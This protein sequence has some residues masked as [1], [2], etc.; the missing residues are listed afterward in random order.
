ML[1][2]L[3]NLHDEAWPDFYQIW[4]HLAGVVKFGSELAQEL[5]LNQEERLTV[6]ILGLLHDH[7]ED[8]HVTL[9]V[10]VDHLRNQ[11]VKN[12]GIDDERML[13]MLKRLDLNNS[14]VLGQDPYAGRGEWRSFR[15]RYIG[16]IL[17]EPT[18]L[19]LTVKVADLTTNLPKPDTPLEK[20]LAKPHLVTKY[21]NDFAIMLPALA[22]AP[23]ETVQ[24]VLYRRVS[25]LG[26][27][28]LEKIAPMH[29]RF[30]RPAKLPF[31]ELR[32]A[33]EEIA[34]AIHP[35]FRNAFETIR[36]EIF[37]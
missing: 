23:A 28:V 25:R 35:D 24:G 19:A 12:A 36:K 22:N 13:D 9:E 37:R 1:F 33:I 34:N 21:M 27:Q 14:V 11:V 6:I 4:R 7:L 18:G 5:H 17:S 30:S 2:A 3:R 10:I 15:D 29:E 16:S 26:L 8:G 20:V 32:P 31:L